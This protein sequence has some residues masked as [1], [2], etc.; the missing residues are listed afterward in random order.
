MNSLT[1]NNVSLT[2]KKYLKKSSSISNSKKIQ[3]LKKPQLNTVLALKNNLFSQSII[4]NLR[5][6]DVFIPILN[7]TSSNL[8]EQWP[9][10]F[11]NNF[12]TGKTIMNM[13]NN[14]DVLTA[15]YFNARTNGKDFISNKLDKFDLFVFLIYLVGS[16]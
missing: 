2:N 5:T 8:N 16:N 10:K 3:S 9:G 1:T 4:N 12:K 6:D 14:L 13:E 15:N 7:H 11:E